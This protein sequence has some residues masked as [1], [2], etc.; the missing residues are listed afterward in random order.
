MMLG[1][2]KYKR[3]I[4]VLFHDVNGHRISGQLKLKRGGLFDSNV[5]SI[6]NYEDV[7]AGRCDGSSASRR[8][9]GR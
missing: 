9:T 2:D 1:D 8:G 5:V 3:P 6:A 7:V 4:G